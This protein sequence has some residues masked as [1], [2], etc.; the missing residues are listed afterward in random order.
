MLSP[1]AK[2]KNLFLFVFH[3]QSANHANRDNQ[4][5]GG[6]GSHMSGIPGT[7][8]NLVKDPVLL[9]DLKQTVAKFCFCQNPNGTYLC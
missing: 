4:Q 7:V 9:A 8:G 2:S 6:D 3:D 5:K 1:L